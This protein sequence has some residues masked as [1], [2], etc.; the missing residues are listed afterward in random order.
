MLIKSIIDKLTLREKIG[1]TAVIG[2]K[3][4][5]QVYDMNEFFKTQP[6][7][8]VWSQG[9]KHQSFNNILDEV[10]DN[11]GIEYSRRYGMWIKGINENLKV[12][13]FST[14]DAERRV[15]GSC[16]GAS[17]TT[18]ATGIGAAHS[19]KLAYEIGSC[20]A[21]EL[22]AAGNNWI[23]GPVADNPSPFC[24]VSLTRTYSNDVDL[25]CKL[26]VAQIK[27]IQS[28]GVAA[29]AKHF[30]GAD[31]DEY[32]D[33]H[34]TASELNQSVEEWYERQGRIFQAA[35]DAGVYSVMVGHIS[36]KAI[37]EAGKTDITDKTDKATK[38]DKPDNDK[39]V[40][41][42]S[43]DYKAWFKE[44]SKH[45]KINPIIAMD[46]EKGA[47]DIF[48]DMTMTA[49]APALGAAAS[50]K[51]AYKIG[52]CIAAEIKHAGVSWLWS[53][54][55]DLSSRFNS[56]NIGRVFSDSAELQKKLACAQIKGIQSKSVAAGVKHFPGTDLEEYRDPHITQTV[57]S[58]SLDEWERSQGMI[59]Q[60]AVDA[61]AWS[62]MVGH[63]AFPAV[64]DTK[65]N[66]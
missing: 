62:V 42:C 45:L 51:L 33:A 35:I 14:L 17:D 49:G 27:G 66:G 44:I 47:K 8:G 29:T 12:P 34:V 40:K 2:Q 50:E 55:V 60:A 46:A 39:V 36:F 32:R 65:I 10:G 9:V 5:I 58:S 3:S 59:F 28:E 64:D 57:I 6:Y 41:L 18:S 26:V 48:D 24:A 20:V 1:Q 31:K 54:V 22:L 21:S 52:E 56:V 43:E 11:A 13:L 23:W 63:V 61:D 15:S 25:C 37:D 53:P 19:E 4:L 16:L 30:P 7:G 38:E